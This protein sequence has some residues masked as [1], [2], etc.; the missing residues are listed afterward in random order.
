LK[1]AQARLVLTKRDETKKIVNDKFQ[2][3]LKNFGKV[4]NVKVCKRRKKRKPKL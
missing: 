4:L 1:P 3:L 2:N